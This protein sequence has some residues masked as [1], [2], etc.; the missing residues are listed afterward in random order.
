MVATAG[1]A[2]ASTPTL[3]YPPPPPPG[4][5]YPYRYAGYFERFVAAM[6]DLVVLG[7]V[8]A[9]IAIPLGIFAW[10]AWLSAPSYSYQTIW[11]MIWGPMS[12]VVFGLWIAYFTYFEATS[13]QTLG[14]RLLGLRVVD[15]RTGRPPDFLMS[16]ARNVIRVVDWLPAFYFLGFLVAAV[17]TNRQRIGDV[18]AGTVVIRA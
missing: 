5:A 7:I 18:A 13:G 9:I 4:Y 14:K 16:L 2:L 1:P 12:L 17:T 6:M 15:A 11:Q 3:N 10:A 8:A